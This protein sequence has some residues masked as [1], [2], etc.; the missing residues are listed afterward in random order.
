MKGPELSQ[1]GFNNRWQPTRW[2]EPDA[3]G[4]GCEPQRRVLKWITLFVYLLVGLWRIQPASAGVCGQP[5]A[6]VPTNSLPPVAG[7]YALWP[8]DSTVVFDG[9]LRYL[10]TNYPVVFNLQEIE[11][12]PFTNI[13]R[14][15]SGKDLLLQFDAT[16][17][18]R[19]PY[20]NMA[21]QVLTKVA[22]DGQTGHFRIRVKDA[23]TPST[24]HLSLIL[25]MFSWTM[26]AKNSQGEYFDFIHV[27]NATNQVSR[28]WI[29]TTPLQDGGYVMRSEL[30]VFAEGRLLSPFDMDYT[31][32]KPTIGLKL[33]G[34]ARALQVLSFGCTEEGSF[35][36]HSSSLGPRYHYGLDYSTNG[37]DW[38]EFSVPTV[39]GDTVSWFD[40]LQEW[41]DNL[42][43]APM[44]LIRLKARPLP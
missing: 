44:K 4:L 12:G 8:S 30:Q 24:N 32:S 28:G 40:D 13:Q 31:P 26:K 41:S 15:V 37:T 17:A 22:I 16:M 27:Q 9:T 2:T 25:E 35:R 33:K 21:G 10:G 19:V 42:T 38:V 39:Y 34:I 29:E 43:N 3:M 14:S 5:E 7:T 23:A 1:T 18:T 20:A 11:V 6:I 36:V